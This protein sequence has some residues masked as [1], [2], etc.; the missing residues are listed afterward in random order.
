MSTWLNAPIEMQFRIIDGL[1]IRFAESED[2][3]QHALLLSPWPESLLAF[4]ADVGSGT[5]AA[6]VPNA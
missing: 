5:G 3:D 2:R 1:S 4:R 6:Y